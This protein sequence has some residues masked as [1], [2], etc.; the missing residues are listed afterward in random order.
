MSP[1]RIS[2]LALRILRQFR[3]DRRTLALVFLVPLLVMGLLQIVLT[4]SSSSSLILGIVP[5]PDPFGTTLVQQLQS[6]LPS[7][8]SVKVVAPDA[9][10]ST[11]AAGDADGVLVFPADLLAQVQSGASPTLTL[12]L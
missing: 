11:L 9:V 6:R 12:R 10:D 4:S 7:Q 3:H 2:G 8:I 5:P 1:R